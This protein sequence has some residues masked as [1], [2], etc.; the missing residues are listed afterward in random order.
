MRATLLIDSKCKL[1]E[2]PVWRDGG[3]WWTDIPGKRLHRLRDG[4]HEV[5]DQP[6]RVGTMIPTD[7]G[8]WLLAT[9]S[10]F[11]F[12]TPGGE[13]EAIADPQTGGTRFND[14]KASPQGRA[15]AGTIVTD[16]PKQ[17]AAFYRLDPG[18][19]VTE[20]FG[21]VQNSNGLAW[22]GDGRTLWYV[23]TGTGRVD[24]LDH[25]PATGEVS[26]RRP[27]VDGFPGRPDGMAVDADD[28]LWVAQ[29]G[30]GCV[31]RCD[32]R[33]GEHLGRVELPVPNVTCCCFGG[34]SMRTLFITTAASDAA[35]GSGGI[36]TVEDAGVAGRAADVYRVR[37]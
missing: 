36:W 7:D 33:T 32:P 20:L 16:G 2:G 11:H 14:G 35:P 9:D 1:A 3:L 5:Y 25:D 28:K 18:G 37:R 13:R 8:R 22:S 10:G 24:A 34:E 4:D 17:S 26:N 6:D 30:G 31:V 19:A 21:G 27:A 23:D 15:F 12:W 29:F